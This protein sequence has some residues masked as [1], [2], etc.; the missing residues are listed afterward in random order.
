MLVS[1]A[2]SQYKTS[3]ILDGLKKKK[4]ADHYYGRCYRKQDETLA[5]F[6]TG[7]VF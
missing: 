4:K 3:G 6:H 7:L 1:F 2:K 5:E